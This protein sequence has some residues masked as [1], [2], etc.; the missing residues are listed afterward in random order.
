MYS[1]ST[2]G[3]SKPRPEIWKKKERERRER[4]RENRREGR[5]RERVEKRKMGESREDKGEKRGNKRWEKEIA[6]IWICQ[7]EHAREQTQKDKIKI[8]LIHQSLDPKIT[9]HPAPLDPLVLVPMTYLERRCHQEWI[10]ATHR[11][12]LRTLQEPHRQRARERV[13]EQ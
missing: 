5:K 6:R 7:E 13:R 3:C 2:Y 10:W 9:P 1:A 4:V 12:W 11:Q 8:N